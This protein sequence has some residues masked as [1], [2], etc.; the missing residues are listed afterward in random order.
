MLIQHPL[1]CPRCAVTIIDVVDYSK[2]VRNHSPP[3]VQF[4]RGRAY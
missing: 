4:A 2:N 1:F 3:V